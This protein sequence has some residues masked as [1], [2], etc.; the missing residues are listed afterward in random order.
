MGSAVDEERG[1]GRIHG[2]ATKAGAEAEG[3]PAEQGERTAEAKATKVGK[4]QAKRKQL[5]RSLRRINC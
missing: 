5:I 4:A 2:E 1:G 3:E